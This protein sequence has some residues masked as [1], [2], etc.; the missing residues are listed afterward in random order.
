MGLNVP[1][2]QQSLN[3]ADS[4]AALRAEVD[5]IIQVRFRQREESCCVAVFFV[6]VFILSFGGARILECPGQSC[7]PAKLFLYFV[8]NLAPTKW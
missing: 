1:S 7:V 6:F 8:T 4:C 5:K 3:C 2:S